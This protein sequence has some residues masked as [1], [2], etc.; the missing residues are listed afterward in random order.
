MAEQDGS[1]TAH[2]YHTF[3]PLLQRQN[4]T[5]TSSSRDTEMGC[6]WKDG[7]AE[8]GQIYRWVH[9]WR[10]EKRK[11]FFWS[12]SV[13]YFE[14]EEDGEPGEHSRWMCVWFY[15]C[16]KHTGSRNSD[17]EPVWAQ[18]GPP[19]L[20]TWLTECDIFVQRGLKVTGKTMKHRVTTHWEGEALISVVVHVWKTT[21]TQTGCVSACSVLASCFVFRVSLFLPVVGCV[22]VKHAL[23]SANW[24][25]LWRR[26]T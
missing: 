23:G 7:L 22:K 6:C 18:R 14:G 20:W 1:V 15:T 13:S 17:M 2:S 9:R 25:K 11:W 3:F 8:G 19:P 16:H 12:L 24:W 4:R 26:T 10:I 21:T 5:V